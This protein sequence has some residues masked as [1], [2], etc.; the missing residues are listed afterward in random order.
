MNRTTIKKAMIKL[1][2][3]KKNTAQL[4]YTFHFIFQQKSEFCINFTDR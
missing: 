4:S 1:K 3:K 2:K